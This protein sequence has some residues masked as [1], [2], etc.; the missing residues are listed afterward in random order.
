[1][2]PSEQSNLG[3]LCHLFRKVY[4]TPYN[5]WQEPRAGILRLAQRERVKQE[6]VSPGNTQ[7]R[8]TVCHRTTDRTM[9]TRSY[10]TGK[11]GPPGALRER[12][13][14]MTWRPRSVLPA[15]DRIPK[16]Q[17]HTHLQPTPRSWRV[18]ENV[19]TLI[20]L[21]ETFWNSCQQRMFSQ[22]VISHYFVTTVDFF[23]RR[24]R[25]L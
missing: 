2:A 5:E 3:G 17:G 15:P 7:P 18:C 23:R 25:V 6:Y 9:R 10:Q 21:F 11:R 13:S 14:S 24:S 20:V 19:A 8:G 1:M 22:L 4:M 12:L 16:L